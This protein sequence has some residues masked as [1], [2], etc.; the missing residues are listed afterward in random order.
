M[1]VAEPLELPIDQASALVA[2]LVKSDHVIHLK[3]SG[4]VVT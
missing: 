1:M 2:S 3:G 4:G